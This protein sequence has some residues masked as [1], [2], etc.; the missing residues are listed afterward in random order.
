MKYIDI[1]VCL[2]G[3][4][5]AEWSSN[6]WPCAGGA[7]L[8]DTLHVDAIAFLGRDRKFIPLQERIVALLP[9]HNR[10]YYFF[11]YFFFIFFYFFFLFQLSNFSRFPPPHPVT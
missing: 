4:T 5:P 7:F 6:S 11:F 1:F 9:T 2:C 8:S 10:N 3:N